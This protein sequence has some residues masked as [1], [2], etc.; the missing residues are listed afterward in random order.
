M[1]RP[2]MES[3]YNALE[4]TR[5]LVV[6]YD[7]G[8]YHLLRIGQRADFQRSR[9]YKIREGICFE[10]KHVGTCG[11]SLVKDLLKPIQITGCEHFSSLLHYVSGAYAP[12]FSPRNHSLIGV[13]GVTGANTLPNSHT[14][15]VT[16]A[17]TTAIKN[18]I[19]LDEARQDQFVLA[20]SLQVAMN[21]L[22]DGVIVLNREM[23]IVEHNSVARGILNIKGLP[24]E[25]LDLGNVKSLKGVEQV[26]I[27]A[28]NSKK[29]VAREIDCQIGDRMYLANIKT[30]KKDRGKALGVIIQ[31]KNVRQLTEAFQNL[32]GDKPK[33]DTSKMVGSSRKMLEIK[34]MI[35]V[36]SRTDAC[37]IIEGESG[38]GKE[39]IAQSIH[40][41][42]PRKRNPFVVINCA[43]IPHDL[44]E[45]TLFG[46]EKGAFTGAER[47]HI[48]KFELA[49][50]GTLFLDEIGEMSPS[51]QAKMLRAIETRAIERVGG[52]QPIS[53]DV[54]IVAATN[55]NLFDLI[56]KNLF[57]A[58][59][60][61]RL[62][63]FKI[64]LPPLRERK[65][66]IQELTR[67]FLVEFSLFFQ[68]DV[69]DVSPKY[70]EML[71]QYDW[72]GNI[73]EL[74]NAIQ[75]SLARL[76]DA[77]RLGKAQLEGFFPAKGSGGWYGSENFDGQKLTSIERQIAQEI[78]EKS[79]GN[80][81]QAARS[82]GISRATLYR[83]LRG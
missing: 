65:E 8:G 56:Q 19:E 83:K 43:A 51:M 16:V 26:V 76:G 18:L 49:N 54:K 34:D 23:K 14:L 36:A 33:Y 4:K 35:R 9:R 38:S 37:V 58:D 66:D 29:Q 68:I 28:L 13:L 42:S 31:I 46:H 3:I 5:Y 70:S 64:V 81:S 69:P 52:R 15:A 75:Y 41:E 10:E 77:R 82:L 39:V 24:K 25:K 40:N 17:A 12:I 21:A 60:F 47:T 74:K 71:M 44:L 72:P 50:S 48:G 63:V 32:A 73:R 57:R 59:L 45:S 7:S 1:A 11:F 55:K 79:N 78:L 30:M 20:N 2:I 62:N 6:L 67:N 22:E 80:K 27:Q 53:F 61:Y